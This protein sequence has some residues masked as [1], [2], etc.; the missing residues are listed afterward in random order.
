MIHAL[1]RICELQPAYTSH[2][3]D[4]MRERGLLI[5][6][7]LPGI[8]R[9]M[10]PE[11]AAELGPFGAGFKVGAS[12]GI[13][14][15]TEAP[16]VR[17][18]DRRMSPRPT[19]GFY[20]VLHFA[21]DGSAMF[22][23]VGCGSTVW[24]GGDLRSVSDQ[25]LRQRTDWG[26]S[27]VAEAFGGLEP[28]TDTIALGAKAPLPRTFEK[29]TVLARRISVEDLDATVVVDL[30]LQAARR[31]R[32]LYEAQ[33]RGQDLAVADAV[34][35]QLEMLSRPQRQAIGIGQGFGLSGPERK[36]VELR[37]MAVAQDW[38]KAQS[39]KVKNTSK[40]SPFDFLATK[41]GASMKVEVKG[42]TGDGAQAIFMTRNEVELHRRE[43]GATALLIVSGIRLDR[44]VDPPKASG[45]ELVAEIGW[46]IE[47]WELAPMAFRLTRRSV[48]GAGSA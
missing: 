1:T 31:L 9:A 38:L 25:E 13:G 15:K 47:A 35:L 41:A 3:S 46:D 39:Y 44:R 32:A 45:G 27:V 20:V 5:R 36:A 17:I 42:T 18:F 34:E 33:S 43:A 30:I 26:R 6:R 4:A 22:V 11:L 7:T 24:A 2:N 37:A 16:W 40:N 14:R 12:D 21:A 23:T 10:E 48:E 28:F 29:A 19:D 8:L